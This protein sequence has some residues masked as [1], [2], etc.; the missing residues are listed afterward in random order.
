MFERRKEKI[1]KMKME[2]RLFYC[3]TY[4][5][6]EIQGEVGAG[7]QVWKLLQQLKEEEKLPTDFEFLVP[8]DSSP[9]SCGGCQMY[10]IAHF[11]Q[12]LM[13]QQESQEET[14]KDT[15]WQVPDTESCG[16]IAATFERGSEVWVKI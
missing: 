7:L 6:F 5:R 15:N 11:Q 12:E 3:C 2:L 8:T 13:D 1:I 14:Q 10:K 4:N 9:W 16:L